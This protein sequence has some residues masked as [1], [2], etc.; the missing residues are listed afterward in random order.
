[1]A[2]VPIIVGCAQKSPGKIVASDGEVFWTNEIPGAVVS[3]ASSNGGPPVPIAFADASAFGIAVTETTV[4][5]TEPTAGRLMKIARAGGPSSVV[6]SGLEGPLHL[7]TDG[8]N[9]FWTGGRRRDDGPGGQSD[10]GQSDGGQAD[11]GQADGGQADEADFARGTINTLALRPGSKPAILAVALRPYAIAVDETGVYWTDLAEGAVMKLSRAPN[12]PD[13]GAAQ[14]VRLAEGS[15]TPTDLALVGDHLYWPDQAGAIWRAG[16]N[17]G[18]PEM[19]A[20]GTGVGVP[21][22][23]AADEQHVY[24]TSASDRTVK[25]A[26]VSGGAVTIVASDQDEPLFVALDPTT[27]YWTLRGSGGRVAK[28]AK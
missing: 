14:P 18:A 12:G 23:V 19:I 7:C 11:E 16:R 4:Y 2:G 22:A 13:G 26:P 8:S 25:R 15:Q 10:G 24:W 3:R 5:W 6:A 1:M 21:L 9:L 17:G 28:A 27:V 20:S